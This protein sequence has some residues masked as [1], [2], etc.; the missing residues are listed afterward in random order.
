IRGDAPAWAAL[1]GQAVAALT[2]ALQD[3]SAP[4][5]R[6]TALALGGIGQE[7]RPAVPALRPLVRDKDTRLA[8]NALIA[9]LRIERLDFE[10]PRAE[11]LALLPAALEDVDLSSRQWAAWGLMRLGADALPALPQLIEAARE[12]GPSV[13]LVVIEL[14][15]AIGPK[16]A[17]AV[18]ELIRE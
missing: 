1:A 7:A 14:V 17:G 15:G 10:L 18:P 12:G 8:T 16:A 3:E 4:V 9:L 5:R 2:D 13:R 11:A 6:A